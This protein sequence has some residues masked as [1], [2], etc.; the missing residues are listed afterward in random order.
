VAGDVY[1]NGVL[2]GAT[3][4]PLVVHCGIRNVRVATPPKTWIAPG[5]VAQVPCRDAEVL[6]VEPAR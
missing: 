4:T 3:N 1:V 5:A 2:A 6:A